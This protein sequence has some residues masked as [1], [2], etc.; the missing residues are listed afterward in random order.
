MTSSRTP[1]IE[2][3]QRKADSSDRLDRLLRE[4]D[5]TQASVALDLGVGETMV[6]EWCKPEKPRSMPFADALGLPEVVRRALAQDLVGAE[7]AIVAL[8]SQTEAAGSDLLAIARV[9]REAGDVISQH[10]SALADGH[11]SA[12]EGAALER[13]V[14]EAIG[15]LLTVRERARQAQRERVVALRRSR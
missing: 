9:Q 6:A 10:L 5:V 11:M 2:R 15:A 12:A 7:Y 8:P 13:E 4:H 3:E 1:R 14:D